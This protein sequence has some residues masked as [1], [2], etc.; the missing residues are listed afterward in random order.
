MSTAPRIMV[1]TD[2]VGDA[3]LVRKLLRDEFDD[4]AASTDPNRAVQDF[5][6]YRPDV[7]ILAFDGLQAAERYYLGLYRLG[8]AVHAL[9]HRTL[10]LCNKD[11]LRRVYELCK[12]E[13]FDDYVL[14]WPLSHDAPRLPMAV[15]HMLRQLAASGAGAPTAGEF[16]AQARRLAAMERLL[17]EH[18]ARGSE[19]LDKASQSLRQAR[20]DIGL[21]LDGFSQKLSHGELRDLIE[22]KDV[23]GF[24][25]EIDRLKSGDVAA[26]LDEVAAAVQPVRDWA[27][28]LRQALAP[29]FESVR[30]L[31]AL[32]E[33]VRPFV[34]MVDDDEFQHKLLHMM[35]HDEDLELGVATSG[36]EALTVLRRRR[37]DLILMDVALPD[38][39]GVELTRRIRAVAHFAAIPILMVTGNSYKDVVV[40][41]MKA[42]ASGFVV[43]P[44]GRDEL[45]G[46]IRSHLNGDPPSIRG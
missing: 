6:K 8:R 4:V 34:V 30:A 15:H 42:G 29:Q 43:K 44:F 13:Y 5:E 27:G 20:Q 10:I 7:L 38:I 23:P 3:D 11:D 37:P 28:A 12:K 32:A 22:L 16:A 19:R 21:A 26:R 39:D 1:A 41:S 14:F 45:L 17:D 31:Q 40:R 24:Q 18:A 36:T 9:P 33:R 2:V 35:L 46:K 25:R